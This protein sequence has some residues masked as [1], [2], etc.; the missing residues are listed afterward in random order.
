M[1]LLCLVNDRA[2]LNPSQSTTAMAV[3]AARRY[4]ESWI[5]GIEDISL[6]VDGEIVF[7]ATRIG[8]NA[9]TT[10]AEA[11]RAIASTSP[12]SLKT[13][14]LDAVL[15]RTN[16]GRD[17]IRTALH[18]ATLNLCRMA[19]AR[20]VR[21][22]NDPDALPKA[23]DEL[24][25]AYLPES[26]RPRMMV[27]RE[28]KRLRDFVE[29]A[30]GS[31][32]LKPLFGTQGKGVFRVRAGGPNLGALIEVLTAE[33][34]VIAQEY[35]RRAPEGDTRVVIVDG[36]PLEVGGRVCAVRRVPS[37]GE[38]RSNIHLGGRAIAAD[39]SR[40]L[41]RAANEIGELMAAHGIWMAGVDLVG[42]KAV[43]VNVRSPGGLVDAGIFEQTDFTGAAIDSVERAV[44]IA[45]RHHETFEPSLE[46]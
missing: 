8:A 37:G 16:P 32:V 42:T 12:R 35:L 17:K 21:V 36:R 24:F 43:E 10:S 34:Y 14:E 7:S 3:E 44:G 13:C 26:H 33:G 29:S 27:S 46:G 15:I 31:S 28:P 1:R 22:L 25:L 39:P 20:G 9:D 40:A 11:L 5:A 6:D 30:S 41:L 2:G 19:A 4:G 18:E 38:F 23:S 45:P